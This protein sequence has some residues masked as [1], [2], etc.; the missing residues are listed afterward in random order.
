MPPPSEWPTIVDALVA[1][2]DH[3]VAHAAGVRAE[4]VVA[5][6]LGGL[7]RGRAGPAR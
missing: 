1:E 3:Q 4:R 2:R 6:R 7:R 5:A